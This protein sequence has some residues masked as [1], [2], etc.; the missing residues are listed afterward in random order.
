[1]RISEAAKVSGLSA[2]TIRFYEKSGLLAPIPRDAS[3]HRNFAPADMEWLDVISKLRTTGM[4]MKDMQRFAALCAEGDDTVPQR[5]DLL[6]AHSNVRAAVFGHV[7]QPYDAR[8]GSVRVIGTPSTCRQFKRLSDEFAVDQ[9]S[10][11]Y[12]RIT[13]HADGSFDNE[14]VWTGDA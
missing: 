3:G 7:H 1:M 6:Q 8:H 14:L 4:P 2:D 10:P 9:R 5:Y 11:A 13:L 12:R